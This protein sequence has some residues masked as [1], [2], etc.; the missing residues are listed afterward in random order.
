M[1]VAWDAAAIVVEHGA[2]E[3]QMVV[4]L[5]KHAHARL[6]QHR[7]GQRLQVARDHPEQ[8]GLARAVAAGQRD[9]VAALDDEVEP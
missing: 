8:R 7:A 2:P 6:A 5:G 1:L 9:P 4:A 3:R